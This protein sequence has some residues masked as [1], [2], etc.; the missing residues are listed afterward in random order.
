MQIIETP[1]FTKRI[2]LLLSDDESTLRD[3]LKRRLK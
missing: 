2:I 1:E 3:Y